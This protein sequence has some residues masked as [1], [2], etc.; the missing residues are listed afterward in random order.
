MAR[1]LI[2]AIVAA[3]LPGALILAGYHALFSWIEAPK[4]LY[5]TEDL[6]YAK[7]SCFSAFVD[8]FSF[9]YVCT[10]FVVVV[11]GVPFHMYA[12]SRK[13]RGP[14]FYT[15]AGALAGSLI[16]SWAM[17]RVQQNDFHVVYE[18]DEWLIGLA[19]GAAL[20]GLSALTAWLIRRPD[21]HPAKPVKSAP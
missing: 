1:R 5:I 11:L 12:A 19:L 7:N 9:L 10:L 15:V 21:R 4:L 2:V 18:L 8:L 14:F 20:G 13:L 17:L 6:I 3:P 16:A